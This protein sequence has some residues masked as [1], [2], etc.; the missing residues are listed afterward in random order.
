MA[1]SQL[2]NGLGGGPPPEHPLTLLRRA[3]GI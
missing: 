1:G 3:Y 2:Q